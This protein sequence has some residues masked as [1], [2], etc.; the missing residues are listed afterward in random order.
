MHTST[1]VSPQNFSCKP[2]AKSQPENIYICFPKRTGRLF[3]FSIPLNGANPKLWAHQLLHHSPIG[4]VHGSCLGLGINWK[5]SRKCGTC[6][7]AEEGRKENVLTLF[8]SSFSKKI[9]LNMRENLEFQGKKSLL[10][11]FNCILL[12]PSLVSPFCSLFCVKPP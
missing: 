11:T 12:P 8:T 9:L 10:N 5:C 7:F 3:F 6:G 1:E 2:L 4:V